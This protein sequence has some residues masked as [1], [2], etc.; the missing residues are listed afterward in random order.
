[1]DTKTESPAR[2][3]SRI[4]R[5][6]AEPAYVLHAHPWRETSLVL[7]V[8][9]RHHGRVALVAKGA[10]RPH[11]QLR[12]VLLGFQ[13]FAASW[14]GKTEV[15]TLTQAE[16]TGG[17]PPLGGLALL[18]GFYFNELLL[19]MLAR[20]D[21]HEGLFDAYHAALAKLGTQADPRT[22]SVE[23]LLRRFETDLLRG[24][25]HLPPLDRESSSG[26]PLR[27]DRRYRVDPEHGVV[28]TQGDDGLEGAALLAMEAEDW[29][30]PDVAR[31]AKVM[32]RELLHYHL[33]TQP[34]RT[35]QLLIDLH[36]L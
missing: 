7:D 23:P 28:A 1:M 30:R 36:Q 21:P 17:V 16:W 15:R 19:R 31:A 12:S 4:E 29:D 24:L 11:S 32:M 14:S 10:K 3:G 25:G 8:F 2:R 26:A 33:G 35:R 13:P 9:S 27:A 34:L 20:E 5:V 6:H 18:C 22:A